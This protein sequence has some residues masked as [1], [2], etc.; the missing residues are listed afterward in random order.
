MLNLYKRYKENIEITTLPYADYLQ[1]KET[2]LLIS[3]PPEDFH[4]NLQ[5][6]H[7]QIQ[8]LQTELTIS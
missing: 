2:K 1:D 8:Q 3:Q 4:T 5:R 7:A 6:I